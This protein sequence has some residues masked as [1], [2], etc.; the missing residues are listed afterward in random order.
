M[1]VI[2]KCDKKLFLIIL[3]SPGVI[4]SVTEWITPDYAWITTLRQNA[5]CISMKCIV[6]EWITLD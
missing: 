4:H 1:Q 3:Q 2:I 6:M 5:V